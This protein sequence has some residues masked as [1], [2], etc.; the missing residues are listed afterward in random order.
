MTYA[1]IIVPR[2]GENQVAINLIVQHVQTQL[3]SRG[4]KL[5]SKLAESAGNGGQYIMPGT[6]GT[7]YNIY[8][9]QVYI[10]QTLSEYFRP[11]PRSRVSTPTSATETRPATSS[12]STPSG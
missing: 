4:F 8:N 7:L 10:L 5:R 12:S 6:R 2:G 1:D 11:R 3:V 9:C